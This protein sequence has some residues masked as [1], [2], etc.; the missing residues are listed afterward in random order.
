MKKYLIIFVAF[1]LSLSLIG[2]DFFG[3][4]AT[5]TTQVPVITEPTELLPIS[6]A[7]DL[8]L[9]DV[10]KSYELMNDIDLGGAEWKPIGSAAKPFSGWFDG[11]NFTISNYVITEK[12][13]NYNGFFGVV[14]GN[15]LDLT[16]SNFSINYS[17]D[18]MTYAGGLV[19]HMTGNI[20]N[21]N[22]NGTI[23]V[24]NTSSNTYA[25]LISGF[26]SAH[27]TSTMTVSQFKPSKVINSSSTGTIVVNSKN[28]AYVGGITG[29]AYNI[30]L[31]NTYSDINMTVT[32]QKYRAFAGGLI[33]HNFSGILANY[34]EVVDSTDILIEN[35][36]ANSTILIRDGGT[37]STAGGLIG[38]NQY[39]VINESF[40]HST[41]TLESDDHSYVGGLVG[42]DWNGKYQS[43]VANVKLI[44]SADDNDIKS[45]GISG[46]IGS[47]NDQTSV[48][49][50]FYVID[51]LGTVDTTLGE[52]INLANLESVSWYQ[53]TLLWDDIDFINRAVLR[54]TQE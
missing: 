18:F 54:L 19:G 22:V 35:C 25:G 11:N 3:A 28:F 34:E 9:I 24:I 10:T 17:T 48:N 44:I 26:H 36:Y 20:T 33:G 46:F 6:T 53:N 14:T 41:I 30:H 50:G 49:K 8:L 5:T 1:I 4:N 37:W 47:I 7:E 21:V 51:Y 42:D 27:I 32:A 16:I 45:L 31:S 39:G 2:C 38:Y 15:I 43:S 29:K 52:T 13:D 12:N 40:A 23:N